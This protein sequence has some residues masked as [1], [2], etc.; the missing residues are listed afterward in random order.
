VAA[1]AMA[2]VVAVAATAR[3]AGA[4]DNTR[5]EHF[6]FTPTTTAVT[7]TT[8]YVRSR[9]LVSFTGYG[10]A[11]SASV[12][13]NVCEMRTLRAD[14]VLEV[15]RGVSEGAMRY[16]SYIVRWLSGVTV[17]RANT[18][19][20]TS[21][22][23]GRMV[24]LSDG[25]FDRTRTWA[26]LL[27][28]QQ[29]FNTVITSASLVQVDLL[30]SNT[31]ARVFGG[32]DVERAPL[33]AVE[34]DECVVEVVKFTT[35]AASFSRSLSRP[36]TQGKTA[37]WLTYTVSDTAT[38]PPFASTAVNTYLEWDADGTTRFEL[39]RSLAAGVELKVTAYVVEF[40][41]TTVVRMFRHSVAANAPTL[42]THALG[43]TV[44]KS[45]S[46]VVK[47]YELQ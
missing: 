24:T 44:I 27:H 38:S 10:G 26:T 45:G 39:R 47:Q 31:Q 11:S 25:A 46:M 14:G 1:A 32:N 15:S 34:Y 4:G 40:T 28:S 2:A 18:L 36:F 3:G 19:L 30:S 41:D 6:S 29:S 8:G 33:Y 21:T 35:T 42:E 37:H 20:S 12:A 23:T 17:H 43:G 13:A 16:T 9:A 7:F 22:S 5:I